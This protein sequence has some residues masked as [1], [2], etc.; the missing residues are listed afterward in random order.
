MLSLR[1]PSKTF[2][3]ICNLSYKKQ[4]NQVLTNWRHCVCHESS[5]YDQESNSKCTFYG[6]CN[7]QASVMF[8]GLGTFH[9]ENVKYFYHS[10]ANRKTLWC[11]PHG[12][13][14]EC[15]LCNPRVNGSIPSSSKLKKLCIL[16]KI[17]GIEQKQTSTELYSLS[18]NSITTY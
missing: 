4:L 6:G 17:D 8:I 12:V 18:A 16:M 2:L 5:A 14:V 15:W 1:A 7:S 10:H 11:V 3:K 13:E 9:L